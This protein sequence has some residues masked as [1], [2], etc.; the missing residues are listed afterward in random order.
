MCSFHLFSAQDQIKKE[1]KFL[2]WFYG[3]FFIGLIFAIGLITYLANSKPQNIGAVEAQQ[4]TS[5][6]SNV[7]SIQESY[8]LAN[9]KYKELSGTIGTLKYKVNHIEE[10]DGKETPKSVTYQVVLTRED[11][12]QKALSQD[13]KYVF[14]WTTPINTATTTTK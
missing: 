8:R 12:S 7:S 5:I 9:G 10:W 4:I 11:G 1:E 3:I 2:N 13:L 6:L 14:D